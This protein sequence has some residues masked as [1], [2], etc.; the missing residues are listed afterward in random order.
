MTGTQLTWASIELVGL[1]DVSTTEFDA[2]TNLRSDGRARIAARSDGVQVGGT[3]ERVTSV[4]HD[5][6]EVVWLAQRVDF[7]RR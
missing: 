5:A 3:G 1:R 4:V 6:V 7:S 2:L